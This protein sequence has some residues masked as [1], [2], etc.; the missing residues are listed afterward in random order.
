VWVTHERGGDNTVAT[1][2]SG[3]A[4]ETATTTDTVL[5]T[6]PGNWR[7]GVISGLV[8]GAVFGILLSV[9][10]T[11]VI[12]VAIPSM[13]GLAPPPNGT[14]GWVVHMSHAAV[15]GVVFAGIVGVL[16]FDGASAWKHVAAGLVFGVVLWV[17]LA[18]LIMPVWLDAV[19][20]PADPPLPNFNQT[21]LVGH[22]VY[23]LGL[24]IAYAALE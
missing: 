22:A 6:T 19:G 5:E 14:I 1:T 10:M 20:S 17:V 2:Q 18:A 7:V 8:G 9:Q 12:E 3:M 23:G 24:G 4:S 21:S 15:L 16:G 13:Y 11:N